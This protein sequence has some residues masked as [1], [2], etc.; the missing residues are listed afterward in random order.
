MF[1]LADFIIQFFTIVCVVNKKYS[2]YRHALRE[3]SRCLRHLRC[4]FT[5]EC[6]P[7]YRVREFFR[8]SCLNWIGRVYRMDIKK[9]LSQVFNINP[10]G[11]RLRGCLK[12]RW[13]NCVQTDVDNAKLQIGK[14]GH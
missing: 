3:T 9:K 12:N 1:S 8:I 13:R 10:Q 11:S 14:R 4:L 7:Q 5:W 6:Q 2:I